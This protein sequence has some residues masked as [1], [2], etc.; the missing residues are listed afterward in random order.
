MLY[1]G[2]DYYPEQETMEDIR[3]DAARMREQGFNVVRIGEFV[4]SLLEP[5][6]G[7]YK[8]GWLSDV[9][10]IL[11]RERISVILCT[12]TACPPIWLVEKHPEILYVDNRGMVRPFGGRRHYCYTN[13]LYREYCR[14]ITRVI[15]E[16]AVGRKNVIGWHIDNEMAQEATG[17]CHCPACQ[18]AFHR[19]LERKY[20][21]IEEFNRRAGTVFWNQTYQR[22][23][24]INLPLKSIEAEGE[25]PL[26]PYFDNPTLRLDF[27]RFCSDSMVEFV[28]N[29]A[30]VIREY[31][32]LPVTT[33]TT[34]VWTSS[35]NYYDLFRHLDIVSV[36]EYPSLRSNSLAGS[37]YS[38]AF[39]RGIKN[40]DRFWV[41]ETSSGGGQGVWA[42]QGVPQPYPGA[43]RQTAIHA[44]A[45]GASLLTYFQYKTFRF[46]AEQLEAAVMDI[47]GVERRRNREFRQIATDLSK[48]APILNTAKLSNKA[49]VCFDYD[50]LW[51]IK[52]KPF[53]KEFSYQNF[54]GRWHK[55]LGR[56]GIDA[57]V[58]P[59][60]ESIFRY[61]VVVLP[62]AVIL[63]DRSKEILK[64]YVEG[65]GTLI[66]T[67]LTGIKGPDNTA[68]RSSVP[69]GLTDLFGMRVG[70]VDPVYPEIKSQMRIVG[71]NGTT[72]INEVWTECLELLTARPLIIYNDSF[73]KGEC[74]ASV[75]NFGNGIAYYFGTVP[76][77]EALIPMVE[78]IC[79]K[80]GLVALPFDISEG[81][82]S[83][84]L[85]VNDQPVWFVFNVLESTTV[86]N[87]NEECL[88][89][90][91]GKA[92]S[93]KVELAAK[94]WLVLC[95]SKDLLMKI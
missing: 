46:G 75:N 62:A 19:W 43:L 21:S 47:D 61:R 93:G 18:K 7:G 42:R 92:L 3:L 51:A 59:I 26:Y 45:S 36:D 65:G 79:R 76:P 5:E 72:F 30:Q 91:A 77:D 38:Y 6:E 49:A 67:W 35:I 29:Q 33:N 73:R 85:Y 83:V 15:A 11:S 71:A 23:D 90:P 63:S 78:Q 64:Q 69:S 95:Q 41:V 34:G 87:I 89:L 56:C 70:E 8:T 50:C 24:Q 54:V 44:Y 1:Y 9:I 17:R 48:L 88:T 68:S 55:I 22:F 57:D 39:I 37:A 58:I 13:E 60:D 2:V 52:I 12:P 32:S 84:T 14:K 66:A 28:V 82:E 16:T 81:I 74:A 20:G 40:Q 53:H 80:A 31:S 25:D 94:E 27:E 86:L 4:W 10:D